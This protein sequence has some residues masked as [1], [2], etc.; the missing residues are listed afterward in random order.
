M[1]LI[2]AI[3]FAV[4]VWIAMWALEFWKTIDVTLVAVGIILAAVAITR[5]RSTRVDASGNDSA[6]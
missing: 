6:S 4:I 5:I 3:T 1:G 2:Y